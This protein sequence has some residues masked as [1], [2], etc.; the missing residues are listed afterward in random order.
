M[1]HGGLE[2]DIKYRPPVFHQ[3]KML[4]TASHPGKAHERGWAA[5][6][7]APMMSL[8]GGDHGTGR[9]L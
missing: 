9:I 5:Y 7:L 6:W 3:C 2:E 1:P 4:M 8:G